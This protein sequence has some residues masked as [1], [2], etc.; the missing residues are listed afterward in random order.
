MV[1]TF[2]RC[3]WCD[4]RATSALDSRTEMACDS[5]ALPHETHLSRFWTVPANRAPIGRRLARVGA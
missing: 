1:R 4:E 5:H 2:T 3:S